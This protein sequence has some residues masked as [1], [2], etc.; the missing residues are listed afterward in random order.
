M[1]SL[2][3]VLTLVPMWVIA[4]LRMPG[5][6][7]SPRHFLIALA[8]AFG[9]VN[10][11]IA[12][13]PAVHA[14]LLRVSNL[15]GL[16][17]AIEMTAGMIAMSAV[18]GWLQLGRTADRRHPIRVLWLLWT[19]AGAFIATTS[20]LALTHHLDGPSSYLAIGHH[21]GSPAQMITLGLYEGYM[22]AVFVTATV[23]FTALARATVSRLTKV[24][25]YMMAIGNIGGAR[26]LYT[27]LY[28][29]PDALRTWMPG[30]PPWPWPWSADLAAVINYPGYT[31]G[32]V[33]LTVP[34]LALPLNWYRARRDL[35]LLSPL[36]RALR[37]AYPDVIRV[38]ESLPTG[39]LLIAAVTEIH[40]TLGLLAAWP[41][42]PAL[43]AR[44]RSA[45]RAAGLPEDRIEPAAHAAW[46]AA[47]LAQRPDLATEHTSWTYG[48]AA[49]DDIA[50]GI[51]W[52]TKVA[53]EYAQGPLPLTSDAAPLS[54]H[55][56]RS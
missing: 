49:P 41:E 18:G 55:P 33:G 26:S 50:G 40:D 43:L 8:L 38:Q 34:A 4:L 37:T 2:I 13:Q 25:L 32:F 11:T 29:V 14:W 1:S 17:F 21:R 28:L 9:C 47:A 48:Q 15:P 5:I 30:V 22:L 23:A 3:L 31:I 56:G 24:G 46:I 16:P 35:R 6:R 39:A 12:P 36:W 20:V 44:A 7:R 45:A 27:L 53:R 42:S 19:V 52:I 54:Q 51:S 10:A